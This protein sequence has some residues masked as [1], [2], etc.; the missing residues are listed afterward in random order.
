MVVDVPEDG[1]EQGA[2]A[3]RERSRACRFVITQP[4]PVIW[5]GSTV[6]TECVNSKSQL[7]AAQQGTSKALCACV[8]GLRL[9][10]FQPPLVGQW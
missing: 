2:A 9:R 10:S 1:V 8:V 4:S 5:G 7:R 3:G 6:G